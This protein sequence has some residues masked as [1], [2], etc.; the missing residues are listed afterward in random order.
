MRYPN[1]L[2]LEVHEILIALHALLLDLKQPEVRVYT[3]L[4]VAKLLKCK[5]RTVKHH[6][7]ESRD[8]PYL[9]LGREVRIM[10]TDLQSFLANQRVPCVLD[11]EVLP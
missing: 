7:Y 4:E 2:P 9:K 11:Q 8:L 6:L 3:I 5:E 1:A 10:E